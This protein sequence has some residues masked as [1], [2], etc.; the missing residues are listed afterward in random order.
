MKTGDKIYQIR[1]GGILI[2]SFVITSIYSIGGFT[3]YDTKCKEG[4]RGITFDE[5]ALGKNVFLTKKAAEMRAAT[6]QR[7]SKL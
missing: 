1:N 5:R 4:K 3:Y 7:R 6:L 2:V